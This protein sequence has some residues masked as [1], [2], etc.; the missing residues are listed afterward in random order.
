MI[1]S[2]QEV[3]VITGTTKIYFM[4]AHPIAHVRSPEV[5]NPAFE[6]RG[7][8]AIMVPLHFSPDGF[9]E[10][11]EGM[12]RMHNLGG[13][14]VSVPLKEAALKLSDE[15]DVTATSVGAANTV[16]REPDGRM[17]C[18][19]FDGPGFISGMLNGGR[20]AEG[21]HVLLVGAGGGGSSIAFSL[22]AAGVASLR[23]SDIAPGRAERLAAAV[24]AAHPTLDVTAGAPDPEGCNLVVNATPCGLHP[25]TDPLPIDVSRL[26]P[27]MLVADIVMKPRMTPLL[28]AAEK[29]GCEIRH[30]DGMLDH[31]LALMMRF[32]GY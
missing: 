18:A 11:W 20:D 13:F 15:A 5:F 8:D 1:V 25:E 9:A 30:G 7:I 16:R 19:N 6:A 28:I 2:G 24:R 14:V 12:R 22:A 26:T 10:G 17:V 32:F 4:I 29:A 21:R 31:Q 3:S 23:I 27:E